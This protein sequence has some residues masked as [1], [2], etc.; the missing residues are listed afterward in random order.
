[1]VGASPN[2][3]PAVAIFS[4]GS[5]PIHDIASL[6]FVTCYYGDALTTAQS[7]SAQPILP[8]M[9][10][11]ILLSDTTMGICWQIWRGISKDE[12]RAAS[13]R[14]MARSTVPRQQRDSGSTSLAG[15]EVGKQMEC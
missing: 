4:S 11:L 3:A 13:K 9:H 5:G 6:S 8:A 14:S 12:V 10:G 15:I 1:M 2:C 7:G